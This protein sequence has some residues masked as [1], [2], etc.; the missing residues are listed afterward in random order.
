MRPR[1]FTLVELL[2]VVAI[3]GLLVALLLPAVQSARA[4][5]RSAACRNN[6][7]QIGLAVLRHCDTHRGEFPAWEHAGEG[8]SWV[9]TLAPFLEGVD[10]VRVCPD[11]PQRYERLR[12]G[13]TGYVVSDYLAAEHVPG[14]VRNLNK[15]QATSKTHAVFEGSDRRLVDTERLDDQPLLDHAHAS[16]WFSDLNVLLGLVEEKVRDDIQ[17]D[18][19]FRAANYLFVDGHVTTIP[20]AT[21]E[22]WIEEQRD[23]ARPQ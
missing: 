9:H 18:R 12:A 22:G 17:L 10:E 14:A 19:H 16:T 21:V 11:E 13:L 3:I 15:L 4:S 1:G 6:L 2:V 23:F 20:A 5:A 7:R 8:R